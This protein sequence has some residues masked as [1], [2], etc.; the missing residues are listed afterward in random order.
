MSTLIV[1]AGPAGCAAALWL[2]DLERP[3][4]WIEASEGVGGTLRRVGNRVDNYLG[5]RAASGIELADQIAESLRCAGIEPTTGVA[6]T[7]AVAGAA[8]IRCEYGGA[9][10]E[11][12]ALLL[13]TGTRPRRLHVEG[14]SR[15]S[16]SGVEISVTR[17][18][19]RYA[20]REV[21]IIGGGDAALE[22]ALLLAP[23]APVIH[24]IHRRTEF[25]AQQ[26]FVD[27]V[28]AA[29]NIRVHVGTVQ[30]FCG[31]AS[32]EA[33]ELADGRSLSVQGAFVRIGVEAVV[34]VPVATDEHGYV[35][36]DDEFRTSSVGVWA[37]GD[38]VSARHQSVAWAAGTAARAVRS[39]VDAGEKV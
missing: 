34:P 25:N 3:Y 22:G 36:V 12:T 24:L 6:L 8:A 7:H 17:N 37:C 28:Q 27:A 18:L 33:V 31:A 19:D 30:R 23:R 29:P 21:C 13:A 38:M 39:I 26:R 20:G 2:E 16:T 15:L 10:H 35:V 4:T 1:G 5:L 14:E 11:H 9:E 32:L